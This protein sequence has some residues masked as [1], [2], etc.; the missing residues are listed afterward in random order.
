MQADRLDCAWEYPQVPAGEGGQ[1]L[2][3][4]KP[5]IVAG[6]LLSMWACAGPI[7]LPIGA[8]YESVDGH[9]R[10]IVQSDS[11]MDVVSC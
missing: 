1:M 9:S 3:K 10:L 11:E 2:P 5:I 4:P 7:G 8:V 6:L